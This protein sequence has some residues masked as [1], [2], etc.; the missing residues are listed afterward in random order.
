MSVKGQAYISWFVHEFTRS[1]VFSSVTMTHSNPSASSISECNENITPVSHSS[2]YLKKKNTV[3]IHMY[4][5]KIGVYLQSISYLQHENERQAYVVQYDVTWLWMLWFV[6]HRALYST[7]F[8]GSVGKCF[9]QIVINLFS[10]WKYKKRPDKHHNAL[11]NTARFYS[12]YHFRPEC[13]SSG[14]R[15]WAHGR[16]VWRRSSHVQYERGYPPWSHRWAT[17]R[18]L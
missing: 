6:R 14:S 9:W 16:R 12:Y 15:R 11:C 3:E 8:E 17:E 7:H 13:I 18:F 4:V 10:P 2:I 5:L 1:V